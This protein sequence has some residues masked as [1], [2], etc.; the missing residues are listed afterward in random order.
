MFKVLGSGL[1]SLIAAKLL[2][3]AGHEVTQFSNSQELGGHF[4][5]MK[6]CESH[7]DMGMVLLE[8]DFGK[9]SSKNLESYDGEFGRD[10]RRYLSAVFS[11]LE[12]EIGILKDHSVFSLL[13]TNVI[14]PDY[15]IGDNLDF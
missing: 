1:D 2:L 14:V 5:G 3:D 6:S 8:P 10:S 7:H 11:W 4:R 15:F 13:P 9:E 12:S